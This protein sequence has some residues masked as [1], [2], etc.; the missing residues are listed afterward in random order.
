MENPIGCDDLGNGFWGGV[1]S[2]RINYIGT[3][4]L[5]EQYSGATSIEA[6]LENEKALQG[7]I[8]S[9]WSRYYDEE[10]ALLSTLEGLRE[11]TRRQECVLNS[12]LVTV[13]QHRN[14]FTP[15][16]RLPPEILSQIFVFN[17]Q[18]R[19]EGWLEAAHT[20]SLVCKR[21]RE[22][23]LDCAELWSQLNFE[24]HYPPR[25]LAKIV[26]RARSVPLSFIGGS[27]VKTWSRNERMALV[28][29]NMH[30]FKSI[31]LRV[32]AGNNDDVDS[33]FK[34]FNESTPML[35]DLTVSTPCANSSFVLPQDFLGGCA[36]N[37]RHIKLSTTVLVPWGSALFSNLTT[38]EVDGYRTSVITCAYRRS[39][40]CLPR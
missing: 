5:P 34:I 37:L 33:L 35:E 31:D 20:C 2:N 12:F 10:R 23:A 36:S 14:L 21:W 13:R 8:S 17:A 22:I 18:I 4:L 15:V 29:N 40:C 19:L 30:R 11:H 39:R 7:S 16:A 38:L 28:V 9:L 3:T 27:G 26:E 6:V 32:P 24:N 1:L 25:R